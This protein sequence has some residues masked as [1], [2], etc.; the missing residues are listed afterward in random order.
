MLG[1]WYLIFR[2][3]QFKLATEDVCLETG[4][5]MMMYKVQLSTLIRHLHAQTGDYFA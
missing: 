2:I 1:M 4:K 3:I 5:I